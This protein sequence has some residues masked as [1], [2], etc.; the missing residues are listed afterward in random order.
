MFRFVPKSAVGP[1]LQ[2]ARTDSMRLR[3]ESDESQ[4]RLPRAT[5]SAGITVR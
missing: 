5:V 2:A 1:E 4:L 3:C